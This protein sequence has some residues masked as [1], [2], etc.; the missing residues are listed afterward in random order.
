MVGAA[1]PFFHVRKL[2]AK[3]RHSEVGESPSQCH[4]KR[5]VHSRARSVSQHQQAV[6][7]GGAEQESGDLAP[8]LGRR[9]RDVLQIVHY[10]TKA[11]MI[12]L[13]R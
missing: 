7:L 6:R 5:M 3:C 10:P 8:I 2:V 11:P 13:V 9:K 4:E 1:S 12:P